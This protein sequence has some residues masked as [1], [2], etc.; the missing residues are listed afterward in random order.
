MYLLLYLTIIRAL[1][2]TSSESMYSANLDKNQPWSSQS[3]K[4][5]N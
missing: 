5:K 4:K 3:Q 2:L 1:P